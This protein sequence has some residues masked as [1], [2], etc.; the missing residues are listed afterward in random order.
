MATTTKTTGYYVTNTHQIME[1]AQGQNLGT[2]GK[3]LYQGKSEKDCYAWAKKNNVVIADRRTRGEEG[4]KAYEAW[5][6]IPAN[7]TP[8]WAK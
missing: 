3:V 4:R 6:G 5:L 7:Y 2:T 1:D 8:P